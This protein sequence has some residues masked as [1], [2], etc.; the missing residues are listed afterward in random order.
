MIGPIYQRERDLIK[1]IEDFLKK[2]GHKS[3]SLNKEI[4]ECNYNACLFSRLGS[5]SF[6]F[7]VRADA[8][9]ISG[10]VLEEIQNLQV[11]GYSFV[12]GMP[13]EI[14]TSSTYIKRLRE[15]NIGLLHIGNR[16]NNKVWPE[17]MKPKTNKIKIFIS[18]VS[19]TPMRNKIIN[20]LNKSQFWMFYPDIYENWAGSPESPEETCIKK[21]NETDVFLAI[22]ED[23][24][25]EI[26]K[27]EVRY[28]FKIKKPTR[29]LVN[30]P[31]PSRKKNAKDYPDNRL[32][33]RRIDLVCYNIGHA[34]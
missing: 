23:D 31:C 13:E 33:S 11:E 25:S 24:I 15:L 2:E 6:V 14:R 28:A 34:R 32:S 30:S 20:L 4:K 17:N 5:Q 7:S 8:D 27:K 10:D 29:I 1:K 18:S 21:I 26:F 16:V 22:L 3:I 12:I 9:T 19:K